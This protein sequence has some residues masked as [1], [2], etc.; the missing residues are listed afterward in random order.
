MEPKIFKK[1]HRLL[2]QLRFQTGFAIEKQLAD[3]YLILIL[4]LQLILFNLTAK[5]RE[6]KNILKLLLTVAVSTGVGTNAVSS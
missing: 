2:W 4:L 1:V 3:F 6:I 5:E